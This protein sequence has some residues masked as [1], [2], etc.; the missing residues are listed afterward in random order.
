MIAVPAG[1]PGDVTGLADLADPATAVVQCA[2]EVP[3]GAATAT[4]LESAGVTVTPVSEE[5][6][7]TAVLTKVAAGEADAGFVY[8]TDA[9]AEDAVE[10]IVPPEAADVVNRYPIAPLSGASD[11]S[12]AALFV[13]YVL[14]EAGRDV[15]DEHGFGAP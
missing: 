11:A 1:N 4:L 8:R 5:Q 2:V 12:A 14:S 15:L 9:A 3:C 10:A 13:A 6:N 7:V